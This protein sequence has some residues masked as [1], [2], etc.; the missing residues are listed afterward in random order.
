MAEIFPYLE[1]VERESVKPQDRL[2]S[3]WVR[4]YTLNA[5][6]RVEGRD[7]AIEQLVQLAGTTA[8][9]ESDPAVAFPDGLTVTVK[10]AVDLLECCCNLTDDLLRTFIATGK[11]SLD[12]A[13]DDL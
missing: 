6:G 10:A 7:A 3:L 13:K 8:T 11:C 5:L 1:A 4:A 9:A 12:V 2:W